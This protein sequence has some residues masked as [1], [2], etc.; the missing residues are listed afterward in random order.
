M[1]KLVY[2]RSGNKLVKKWRCTSGKRKGKVVSEPS[3]CFKPI[4]M[5]KRAK[6]RQV[7]RSKGNQMNRKAQI[8]KRTNPISKQVSKLNKMLSDHIGDNNE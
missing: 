8:A 2:A 4:D 1:A 3:G 6:M 7:R 5:K